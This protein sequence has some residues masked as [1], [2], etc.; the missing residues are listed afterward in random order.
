MTRNNFFKS[1]CALAVAPVAV[2]SPRKNSAFF[3]Q[4]AYRFGPPICVGTSILLDG[5]TMTFAGLPERLPREVLF[6]KKVGE[7]MRMNKWGHRMRIYQVTEPRKRFVSIDITD[8]DA[9]E[10]EKILAVVNSLKSKT[11]P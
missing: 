5:N 11:Q 1:L 2:L 6:E 7:I 10:R 4:S 3:P 8:A 9:P